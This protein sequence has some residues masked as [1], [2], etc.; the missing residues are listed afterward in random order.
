[1][2]EIA[3]VG[4]GKR[5]MDSRTS[6]IPTLA[7]ILF[8]GAVEFGAV[9]IDFAGLKKYPTSGSRAGKERYI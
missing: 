7:L 5:S 4:T 2:V 1:L 3:D 9:G 8:V 6:S